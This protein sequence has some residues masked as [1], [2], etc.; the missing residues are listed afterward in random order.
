MDPYKGQLWIRL[1]LLPLSVQSVTAAIAAY[2][3]Y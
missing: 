3:P 1:R 2:V